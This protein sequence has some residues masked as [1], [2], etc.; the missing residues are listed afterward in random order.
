MVHLKL[1]LE[2]P[3]CKLK[4]CVLIR[5]VNAQTPCQKK[6][7]ERENDAHRNYSRD[8]R[9]KE[10]ELDELGPLSFLIDAGLRFLSRPV[11]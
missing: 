3:G 1:L 10:R 6:S 9:E 4:R 11:R 5:L 2:S 7:D 8:L